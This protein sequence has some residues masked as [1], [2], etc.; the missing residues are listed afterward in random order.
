VDAE[1][2]DH[3]FR[4]ATSIFTSK[5]SFLLALNAFLLMMG[6]MLDILSATIVIVPL[7]APVA[8]K[9][10]ID[11]VHLAVIF[12]ANMQ[13]AYLLP[14]AG[15]DLCV[16]SLAFNQPMTR[17]YRVAVPFVGTLLAAL[18]VIT[19]VPELSLAL[20]HWTGR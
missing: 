10:G 7:I 9:V 4:I 20:L 19:Y 11:P 8:I 5:W 13:T 1:V 17:M 15:I 2:P 3:L 14:P 6:S 16:A 18:L 12:I